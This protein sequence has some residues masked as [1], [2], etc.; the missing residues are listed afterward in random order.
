MGI[1]SSMKL[2][3]A[4]LETRFVHPFTVFLN[5]N[6]AIMHII[7]DK[8]VASQG[9]KSSWHYYCP[10]RPTPPTPPAPTPPTPPPP[11]P[12]PSDCNYHANSDTQ[13]P[14][15]SQEGPGKTAMDCCKG[16]KAHSGCKVAVN[17]NGWCYYKKEG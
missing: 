17:S 15:I 4:A 1:E 8:G 11:A 3:P 7:N 5:G 9:P 12:G 14:V 13:G 10:G 2:A 6:G 16:C